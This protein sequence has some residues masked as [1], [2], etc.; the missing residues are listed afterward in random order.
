MRCAQHDT[1]TLGMTVEKGAE[2]AGSKVGRLA[3][4][5]R[6]DWDARATLDPWH[7]VLFR[8]EGNW[9]EEGA[10]ELDC[11]QASLKL[12][13]GSS[14]R[15]LEIGCGVGRLTWTLARRGREVWALDISSEMLE[16]AKEHLSDRTNVRF[17]LGD[18]T[19]LRGVPSASVDLVFSALTLT[20][21]P[22]RSLLVGYLDEAVRVLAHGG[23]LAVQVNTEGTLRFVARMATHQ[24]LHLLRIRRGRRGLER[25]RT[26]S[27]S[28]IGLRAVRRA[29]EARGLQLS[30][31]RGAGSLACWIHAVRKEE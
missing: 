25:G 13:I 27:G 30:A 31:V 26:W 7:Y 23:R 8:P 20:H 19:T 24:A 21:L 3:A 5:M 22:H 6:R 18:G 12:E 10:A 28:R 4:Q 15:V 14:D 1:V 9:R 11:L 16:R 2:A 29:L 17:I